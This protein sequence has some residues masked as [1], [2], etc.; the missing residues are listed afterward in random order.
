MYKKRTYGEEQQ[1]G[2]IP[3]INANLMSKRMDWAGHVWRS[4]WIL[5]KSLEAKIEW[6]I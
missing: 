6:N 5:K 1:T 4:N 2:K 3:K